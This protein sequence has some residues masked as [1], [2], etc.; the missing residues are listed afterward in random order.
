[1]HDNSKRQEELKTTDVLF[2]GLRP[3]VMKMESDDDE[4]NTIIISSQ[5][6]THNILSVGIVVLR[7]SAVHNC[8]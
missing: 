6:S 5:A 7:S 4:C 3:S 2:G 8:P 1:M